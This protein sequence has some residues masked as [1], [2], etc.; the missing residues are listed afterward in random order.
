MVGGSAIWEFLLEAE[1]GEEGVVRCPPLSEKKPEPSELVSGS[2]L[3]GVVVVV[4]VEVVGG[5]KSEGTILAL[6]APRT[7]FV[8]AGESLGVTA[9]VVGLA[10]VFWISA[11]S[12]RISLCKVWT[13]KQINQVG[14]VKRRERERGRHNKMGEVKK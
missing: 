11:S 9:E 7:Y 14:E 13:N 10:A 1:V 5:W 6:L 2:P 12:A 8:E 3:P 4:G